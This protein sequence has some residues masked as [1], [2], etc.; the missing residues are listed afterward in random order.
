MICS[1]CGG[2]IVLEQSVENTTGDIYSTTNT[3]IKYYR[4][5][6]CGRDPLL[7]AR[8]ADEVGQWKGYR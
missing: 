3:V 4:C 5:V 1:I 6:R 7:E 2:A 8:K